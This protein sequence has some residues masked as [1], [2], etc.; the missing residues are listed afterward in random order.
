MQTT[1]T[2]Y[3]KPSVYEQ[4]RPPVACDPS[5]QSPVRRRNMKSL[6]INTDNKINSRN[7]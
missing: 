7:E 5:G 4:L 6:L 3:V 1:N 2:A